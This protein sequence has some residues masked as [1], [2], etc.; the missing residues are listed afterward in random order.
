MGLSEE[1]VLLERALTRGSSSFGSSA[2]QPFTDNLSST[3]GLAGGQIDQ[4][5]KYGRA[6]QKAQDPISGAGTAPRNG[7]VRGRGT[8]GVSAPRG[9]GAVAGIS[10]FRDELVLLS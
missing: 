7:D 9:P 2:A 6:V 5:R 1:K 8:Y 4:D 3:R 10:P